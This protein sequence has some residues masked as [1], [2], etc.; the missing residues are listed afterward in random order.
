MI[1]LF[2]Y[3][4]CV[5]QIIF[6]QNS[7]SSNM[8]KLLCLCVFAVVDVLDS[9]YYGN[10]RQRRSID[11]HHFHNHLHEYQQKLPPSNLL[12]NQSLL[13]RQQRHRQARAATSPLV[14]RKSTLGKFSS[15]SSLQSCK[16]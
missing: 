1:L 6:L 8:K 15:S 5:Q 10:G 3:V 12:G 7:Y 4:Y 11:Q 16:F 13:S 14:H 9:E 2:F